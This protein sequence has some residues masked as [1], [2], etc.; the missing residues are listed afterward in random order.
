V[1]GLAP[2]ALLARTMD[3]SRPGEAGESIVDTIS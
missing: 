2:V 3:R 1:V